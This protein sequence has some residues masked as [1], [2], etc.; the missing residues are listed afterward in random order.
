MNTDDVNIGSSI[1]VKLIEKIIKRGLRNKM[2]VS[3]D[4]HINDPITLINDGE[5]MRIHLNFDTEIDQI[6]LNKLIKCIL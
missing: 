5:K 2:G 3:A 1:M 6:Q 4:I